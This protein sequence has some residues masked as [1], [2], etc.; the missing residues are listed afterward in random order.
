M[1]QVESAVLEDQVVDFLLV[2]GKVKDKAST[3]DEF[4]GMEV[5]K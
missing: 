1:A 2:H 5:S 4:M 3:F